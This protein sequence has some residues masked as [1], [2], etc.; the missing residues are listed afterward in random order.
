[1]F[2]SLLQ[3]IDQKIKDI[4]LKN[5]KVK[6]VVKTPSPV[7]PKTP[8]PEKQKTPSPVKPKTPSPFIPSPFVGKP[9]PEKQLQ[10]SILNSGIGQFI[11]NSRANTQHV[12]GQKLIDLNIHFDR[13]RRIG[14]LDEVLQLDE[15]DKK[16]FDRLI[17]EIDNVIRLKGYGLHDFEKMV[18]LLT[19][20]KEKLDPQFKPYNEAYNKKID[21][22]RREKQRKARQ[23]AK[24]RKAKANQVVPNNSSPKSPKSTKS[25]KSTKSKNS[26]NSCRKLTKKKCENSDSCKWIVGD[27]CF[28]K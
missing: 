7:K 20:F 27:G 17:G 14:F 23:A 8:S 10:S 13:M 18:K 22:A 4:K 19:K 6:P 26:T 24:E 15:K 2:K 25:T 21:E 11:I 28:Q 5:T 12:Q 3:K 1:M 9:T 16:R